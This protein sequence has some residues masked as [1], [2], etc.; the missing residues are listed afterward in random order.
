[1]GILFDIGILFDVR[2]SIARVVL[3][4]RTKPWSDSMMRVGLLG[5]V[6]GQGEC[7]VE[8]PVLPRA[9]LGA[10]SLACVALKG[11]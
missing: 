1:M 11:G 5:C 9:T 6:A 10:G 8:I 2:L 7:N 3:S 4:G